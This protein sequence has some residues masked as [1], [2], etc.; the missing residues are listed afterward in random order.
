MSIEHLME[1]V[2]D[3]IVSELGLDPRECDIQ[4]E[5]HPPATMDQFYISI[6]E[7]SIEFPDIG[8]V[9]KE[10]YTVNVFVTLR[11]GIFPRD[12]LAEAYDR[13]RGMYLAGMKSLS[14]LERQIITAVNGNEALRVL[15]CKKL[16]ISEAAM[17]E[18]DETAPGAL[19]E[20]GDIFQLPLFY[21][22]RGKTELHGTEW[23]GGGGK[24]QFFSVRTLPFK[25]ATRTQNLSIAK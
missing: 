7:G 21:Q 11:N 24:E 2:R 8:L 18:A 20:Y 9:F 10:K 15:A 16:G 3:T 12:R 17:F 25:G 1:A 22:G 4:P 14:L 23:V 13:D 5:G 19:G 6:D